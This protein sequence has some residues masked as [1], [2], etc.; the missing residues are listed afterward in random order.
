MAHSRHVTALAAVLLASVAFQAWFLGLMPGGVRLGDPSLSSAYTEALAHGQSYLLQAPDPRVVAAKDPFGPATRGLILWDTSY[1]AG[2]YYM[3]F[4]IV[5]FAV[6]MVPLC[7]I[8]GHPP[9]PELAILAFSI[10]GY[11]AYGAIL[12]ILARR[13]EGRISASAVACAMICVVTASG[14]WPL[15]GRP[16]IFEIENAAAYFLF[17]LSLLAIAYHEIGVRTPHSIGLATAAAAL[18]MGCRP[19]YFPAVVVV[20]LWAICRSA[21][22][23]TARLKRAASIAL[24]VAPMAAIGA[25]LAWWNHHRFGNILDFG[26]SHTV[27]SDPSEVRPLSALVNLPYHLHRYLLGAPRLGPYFPFIEGQREAAFHLLP[28]QEVSNQVYGFLLLSPVLLVGAAACFRSGKEVRPFLGVAGAAFA[29]NFLFLGSLTMS[30]Y[31][32]PAD[33]LGPLV[34]ASAIGVCGVRF[35]MSRELTLFRATS[36]ALAGYGVATAVAVT[37]SVAQITELFDVRRPDAFMALSRTANLVAYQFERWAGAGPKSLSIDIV[38]PQGRFGLSEPALVVGENGAQDFVYFYY[39]GPGLLQFG[40]ES[41]GL[42]GVV[43]KPVKIDYTS[44]HRIEIAL[45]S[46]LPPNGYPSVSKVPQA[47]LDEERQTIVISIDGKLALRAHVHLHRPGALI[48][49]GRSPYDAAFGKLFTGKIVN[50]SWVPLA[51]TLK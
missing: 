18:V 41:M 32:Y 35:S 10:A 15:M 51:D 38:F 34:I 12:L 40:F 5:P 19:N 8:T 13:S 48:Y 33:F 26:L 3:Y 46:F 2:H 1:F 21:T 29:G 24:A 49:V 30:C 4:G 6:F 43:S 14:T 42:G 22:D 39:T 7:L 36:W 44:S 28:W 11:A 16:A 27:S 37:A 20:A 23:P 50:Q 17:A 45:G 47:M 9:S 31:R 25:A